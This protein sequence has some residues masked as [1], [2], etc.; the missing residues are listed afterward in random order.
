VQRLA[1]DAA[2]S[3]TRLHFSGSGQ[4]FDADEQRSSVAASYER[5]LSER[6]TFDGTLG[7]G[8]G[9]S[10]VAEGRA[11]ALSFGPV[12]SFG[13]SYRLVDDRGAAPFVLLGL[14][15]SGAYADTSPRGAVTTDALVPIDLRASV[16][17][18][19]T[20]ARVMAPYLA[21]RAFGGPVF[22]S[23]G[24]QSVTGTDAYHF[25]IGGGFSLALG[26][27]DLHLEVAPLGERSLACGAGFAL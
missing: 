5:R 11:Y 16:T 17:V 20:V 2:Y 27:F 15:A 21:A 22:W 24:G 6:L 10:L 18:G 8:T 9:G 1:L 23:A 26:R 12:L 13:G 3:A 25:Q 7:V 4:S 14:S 19:K